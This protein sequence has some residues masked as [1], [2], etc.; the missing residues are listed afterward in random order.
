[1]RILKLTGAGR[2]R[3]V[4]AAVAA[5]TAPFAITSDAGAS[6]R[7]AQYY[8]V[9][10]DPRTTR[11]YDHS[12]DSLDRTAAHTVAAYAVASPQRWPGRVPG[13]RAADAS[14]ELK[15]W[16]THARCSYSSC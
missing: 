14:T 5:L 2:L 6:L 8:A 9:H 15:P 11:R 12:R 13:R 3:C 10:M 4:G 16:R 1:M 7:D